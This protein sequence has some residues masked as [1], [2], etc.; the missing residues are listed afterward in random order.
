M[1]A[2]NNKSHTQSPLYPWL[3]EKMGMNTPL[4]LAS[5]NPS[6]LSRV[7]LSL[8][9]RSSLVLSELSRLFINQ[10]ITVRAKI[11]LVH[12]TLERTVHRLDLVLLVLNL[13]LVK[14]VGS[15][16]VEMSRCLP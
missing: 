13:H 16:K 15:V 1:T 9:S 7:S 4:Y 3:A 12:E 5:L 11:I 8:F 14:H 2:P 6:P 10:K